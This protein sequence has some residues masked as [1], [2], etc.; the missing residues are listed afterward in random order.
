MKKFDVVTF[1]CYGTLVDWDRGISEAFAAAAKQAGVTVAPRDVLKAYAA[2]EP[3]VETEEFRPYR[4]VLATTAARVA[5]QFSWRLSPHQAGFLAESLPGWSLFPDTNPAL[6]R[7]SRAGIRL[8]ILSNVDDDLLTATRKHFAVGFDVVVTAQ[9]V[10]SYK[11]ALAHFQAARSR[12]GTEA[13]WLHA[14]QSYFHDVAP[15]KKLGIAVAWV[16][17]KGETAGSAGPPDLESR[18]LSRLADDLLS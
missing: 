4:E 12:I 18:D 14:A 9:Q 10:R 6:T 17:R 16:N 11:P 3:V 2:I 13:R 5:A 8:G 15:C 1:D 7:L